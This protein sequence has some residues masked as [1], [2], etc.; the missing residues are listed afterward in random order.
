MSKCS[1]RVHYAKW[2]TEMQ[3]HK[4]ATQVKCKYCTTFIIIIIIIIMMIIIII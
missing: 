2:S 1:L 4:S 3:V